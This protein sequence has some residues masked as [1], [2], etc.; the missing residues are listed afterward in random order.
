VT[1]WFGISLPAA[2]GLL[3]A[4][5]PLVVDDEYAFATNEGAAAESRVDDAG[6]SATDAELSSHTG[7]E[8]P[9]QDVPTDADEREADGPTTCDDRLINGP[10]TDIDCGGTQCRP[11]AEGQ[12]CRK[13]ED[14]AEGECEG[15]R[16][17]SD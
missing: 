3:A 16:C 9:G 1:R 2:L 8:A 12:A 11:C 17:A 7:R 5:C 15:G 4:G 14:C 13:N 10:E 6:A